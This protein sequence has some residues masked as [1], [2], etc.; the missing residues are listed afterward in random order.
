MPTKIKS[1]VSKLYPVLNMYPKYLLFAGISDTIFKN[2]L[3]IHD[4][5]FLK[6]FL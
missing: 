3:I 6:T 1:E 4:N 5:P 2:P